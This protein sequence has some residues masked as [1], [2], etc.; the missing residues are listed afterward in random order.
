MPRARPAHIASSAP[1]RLVRAARPGYKPGGDSRTA[2]ALHPSLLS[3]K[4][5]SGTAACGTADL[6]HGCL[7]D[8]SESLFRPACPSAIRFS[9][10]GPTRPRSPRTGERGEFMR[11]GP[12]PMRGSRELVGWCPPRESNPDRP[13]RRREPCPLGQEGG[14]LSESLQERRGRCVGDIGEAERM[15]VVQIRRLA[16]SVLLIA[17]HTNGR[18]DACPSNVA[19][20]YLDNGL[21]AV[22]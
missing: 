15:V 1:H 18:F 12:H 8:V 10:C 2:A 20:L 17:R 14:R 5:P 21:D 7:L 9:R 16:V 22:L 6:P 13:L 11:R 19:D 4:A 3:V